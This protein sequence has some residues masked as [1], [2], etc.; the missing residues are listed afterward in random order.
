M[1]SIKALSV[2]VAA[3]A[4]VIAPIAGAQATTS[5]NVNLLRTASITIAD[6]HVGVVGDSYNYGDVYT[7]S[8]DGAVVSGSTVDCARGWDLVLLL[9]DPTPSTDV[10]GTLTQDGVDTGYTNY[11]N[12]GTSQAFVVIDLGQLSTFSKFEVY[13]MMGSDGNVTHAQ[14]WVSNN[15]SDTSPL[16]NDGSWTSVA[17]GSVADGT[18]QTGTQPVTNTSVTTFNFAE[19]E[20]R[21]VMIYFQNDGSYEN[22]DWIEVAGA[23]L[24]GH[25]GAIVVAPALASTGFDDSVVPAALALTVA[26]GLAILATRSRKATKS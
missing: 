3:A 7:D 14:L 16:Q 2:A 26:G 25:T 15:T 20:G 19:T 6:G 12:D 5:S 22:S 18:P 1:K 24:F 21:Y 4:L 11:L 8:P 17:D 9:C 10:A 13:Q 23:K